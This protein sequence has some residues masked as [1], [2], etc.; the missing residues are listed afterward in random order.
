MLSTL[1][2]AVAGPLIGKGLEMAQPGLT[3]Y[4]G[5]SETTLGGFFQDTFG[6]KSTDLS[7]AGQVGKAVAG[8][9]G[10]NQGTGFGDLPDIDIASPRAMSP[11]TM[12]KAGVAQQYKLPLG[13][14]NT[15]PNYLS[16]PGV[17]GQL[18][19]TQTIP[20]PR[21]NVAGLKPNIPLGSASIKRT[22]KRL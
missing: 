2:A 19:R 20:I 16:K 9:L 7:F 8:A 22:R 6:A 15:V 18:A 4:F 14:G 13:N 17:Q 11:A 12:A 21:A 5:G 1:L 10:A 3:E